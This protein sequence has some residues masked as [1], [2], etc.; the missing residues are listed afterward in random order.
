MKVGI[1]GSGPGGMITARELANAGIEVTLFE[2]GKHVTQHEVDAF[3]VKEMDCKYT[4]NGVTVA[5]GKPKVAYVEGSCLGGGSEVNA[6]LYHRTP[7]KVFQQWVNEGRIQYDYEQLLEHMEFCE[8]LVNVCKM[9]FDPPP[10]SLKLKQ[11]AE[12]LNWHCMEVPRWYKYTSEQD[13]GIRSGVRQSM[14][15]AV[16]PELMQQNVEILTETEVMAVSKDNVSGVTVTYQDA[17][18]SNKQM[19][20]DYVFICCGAVNTPYLLQRSG[21]KN[22]QIGKSL[23]LHS[24]VKVTARFAEAVNGKFPG[25]PVH[26]SKEFSPDFSIGGSIS[27]LPFLAAGLM[28]KGLSFEDIAEMAPYLSTYY[29]MISDGIGSVKKVPF[30]DRP[31]V[32]F[33]IPEDGIKKL[34]SA[35]KKLT[36]LMFAAEALEVY[37]SLT[38]VSKIKK[39][40]DWKQYPDEFPANDFNLMTIHLMGSCPIGS[41]A[42]SSV[43]NQDG[44]MHGESRVYIA[45]ASIIPSALGVNP[46]GTN[47]ALAR[48]NAL[49][50]LKRV[51][52]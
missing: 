33:K 52:K 23:R 27:S 8:K 37:P 13:M 29:A 1:I 39:Q 5:L 28:N 36:E 9:P 42:S 44:L 10:A 26:Q 21:F 47:M 17:G 3:S 25:I 35:V 2:K 32:Q 48:K 12:K 45:D 18:A 22:K 41:D 24:T 40:N 31:L 15:E 16:L 19:H 38:T 7:E 49:E 34:N 46:Q 30:V 4:D 50:F 43:V 51:L 6:G 14:T 20:F 11:G